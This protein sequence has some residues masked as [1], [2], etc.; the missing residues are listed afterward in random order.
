MG[1]QTESKLT[2]SNRFDNITESA[3][4]VMAVK[5]RELQAK[6]INVIK[7]NLGEPD[8]PTP[9]YIQDAAKEAIDEGKYFSYP[10]VPGYPELRKPLRRNSKRKWFSL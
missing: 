3:T 10:P 5:A 7:L 6:G 8:F 4:L 9:Q 1:I 2:L